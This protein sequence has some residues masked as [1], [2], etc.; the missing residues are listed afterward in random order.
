MRYQQRRA[1]GGRPAG[2]IRSLNRFFTNTLRCLLHI[3]AR[4]R[5][6]APLNKVRRSG[7]SSLADGAQQEATTFGTQPGGRMTSTRIAL[8][9]HILGTGTAVPSLP[10]VSL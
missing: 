8:G 5:S 2:K 3:V 4:F 1:A 7:V 6:N 10:S 9:S